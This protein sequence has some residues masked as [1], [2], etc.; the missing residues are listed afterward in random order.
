MT[1][2]TRMHGIDATRLL[3]LWEDGQARHPIDRAL[4]LCA[5]ARPEHASGDWAALP[6]GAV[7][8]TL[9]QLRGAWFGTTIGIELACAQCGEPLQTQVDTRDLLASARGGD[10]PS[11][12]DVQGLVF[13]LPDSRDLASVVHEADTEHAARQLLQRCCTGG[14]L[15]A[16]DDLQQ[17]LA[18]AGQALEAADPLADVQLDVACHACGHTTPATLDPGSVV[19]TDVQRHARALLEQVHA[20]ARAYGWSEPEVLA[21]GAARRAAYLDLATG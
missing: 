19:W 5:C 11:R 3:D 15:A 9:L 4:M 1:G 10:A 16:G 21:L 18:L 20:L 2:D 17:L 8:A 13:R 7:N 12:V 14:P 6:L